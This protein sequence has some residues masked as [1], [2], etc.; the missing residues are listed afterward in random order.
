M[1]HSNEQAGRQEKS[2]GAG[3]SLFRFFV[4]VSFAAAVML[5]LV[6]GLGLHSIFRANVIEEAEKDAIRISMA[7]RD[8]QIHHFVQVAADQSGNLAIPSEKMAEVDQEM[9]TFLGPFNILKIK[10]FDISTRIIY[11]TDPTIIG[12]MNEDNAKLTTALAGRPISKFETKGPVRDLA[13]EERFNVGIVESYVP[14]FAEDGTVIGSFEIY[15]DVTT[16][17]ALAGRRLTH[18]LATLAVIGVAIFGILALIMRRATRTIQLQ[19]IEL[20]VSEEKYRHLFST[21]ADAIVIF[22]PQTDRII[23]ANDAASALYGCSDGNLLEIS[24]QEIGVDITHLLHAGTGL[25]GACEAV[26]ECEHNKAD[27]TPFSVEMSGGSFLADG[28]EMMFVVVRDITERRRAEAERE[29]TTHEIERFNRLV[30]GREKR[31]VELK[32][33]VNE[34]ARK[35]GIAPPYDVTSSGI[36]Q[37]GPPNI[38]TN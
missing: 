16:D 27:G 17:L 2:P 37:D 22:D 23:D 29:R 25:P 38:Q 10:V 14:V 31:M 5:L 7:L 34:L 15:K 21:V 33:E 11:S 30:V 20:S 35:A 26:V 9:R 1:F 6:A 19:T 13:E 12:K 28:Q 4:T 24:I 32:R 18:V 3:R 36:E 8:T